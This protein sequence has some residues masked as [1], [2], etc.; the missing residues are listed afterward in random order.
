M[1]SGDSH[2]EVT[3][4]NTLVRTVVVLLVALLIGCDHEAE[5]P[6]PGPRVPEQATTLQDVTLFL[7]TP[8]LRLEPET[9]EFEL[10]DI[11]TFGIEAITEELFRRL[12]ERW[13]GGFVPENTTVRASFIVGGT[14]VIDIDA[15]SLTESWSTGSKTEI[16]TVQAI[17]HSVIANFE[18]I[19]SVQ[20]LVN[21]GEVQTLAG[22]LDLSKPIR[23]DRSLIGG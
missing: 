6:V 9:G 22:H 7:P 17:V 1:D 16:L 18:E 10:P 15:P 23:P 4:L 19:E 3:T 21:G 5:A 14:A 2:H 13:P 12:N 8:G 20:I 11:D